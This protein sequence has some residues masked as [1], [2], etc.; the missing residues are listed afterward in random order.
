[1]LTKFKVSNFKNFREEFELDFTNVKEYKFNT[2]CVKNGV[3]NTAIIYGKNGVGKS[4][5]GFAIF[6]IVG[7]LTDKQKS[8]SDYEN[9][10]NAY[11]D[12]YYAEFE[13]NFIIDNYKVVYKYG[14]TDYETILFEKFFI[15]DEIYASIDR[16]ENDEA[17]IKF[18]GAETLKKNLEDNRE[19]SVL[20]YIIK[21][22]IL[23]SKQENIIL[24]RFFD[25]V[26][27]MLFFR[28]LGQNQ[29]IGFERG[30]TNLEEYIIKKECVKDFEEFLNIAGI[31]CKLKVMRILGEKRLFFDFERKQIP[32]L[33][34]ASRG[35]QALLL[36]YFWF[37]KI[38]FEGKVSFLFIDEF[39]AYYHFELSKLIVEKL[40]NTKIQFILT[41]HNT[42]VMNN[43]IMRP[44]C[45]FVMDK[46]R[47]ISLPNATGKELREG[48]NLE[49]IYKSN[50]FKF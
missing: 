40:K 18:R 16:R 48:H 34:I 44:D 35:T 3:V 36:F 42:S 25:F 17:F 49:K 11:G 28:S 29:Y 10:I 22:T 39:D 4:N 19:I 8:K 43:E 50:G 38:I 7:H 6:D 26:E 32:F 30:S 31:D 2:E 27:G 23:E 1:M 46:S 37:H 24:H 5:L 21:N 20:R 14:K 13:Y 9:Y 15:N 33:D 45:Y 47:I 41:T 12:K